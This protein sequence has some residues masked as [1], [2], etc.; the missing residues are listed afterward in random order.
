M[1]RD[2]ATTLGELMALM[3]KS[4]VTLR[5]HD[6]ASSRDPTERDETPFV[7]VTADGKTWKQ[8]IKRFMGDDHSKPW[9]IAEAL[10]I[11]V[12]RVLRGNNPPEASED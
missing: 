5:L 4:T 7:S 6:P 8:P 2:S 9:M 3:K 11:A 10:D 1:N 12:D